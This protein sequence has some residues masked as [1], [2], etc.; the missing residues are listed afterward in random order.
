VAEGSALENY[1]ANKDKQATNPA[2]PA[3][4]Q[5]A[6]GAG[7]NT[8]L[9]AWLTGNGAGT[10][11]GYQENAQSW[12]T[13]A[14]A[15]GTN[16]GWDNEFVSTFVTQ[17]DEALASGQAKDY[18]SRTDATGV[19]T[20]DHTNS[21]G[22]ESYAFG[23]VYEKGKKVGNIYEMYDRDEANL[24]IAPFILDDDTQ[25]RTFSASDRMERL[26]REITAQKEDRSANF[27]KY[28]SALEFEGDVDKRAEFFAE[29]KVDEGI[30]GA[31][32]ILGGA[33][34]YGG[35]AAIAGSA[36]PGVGTVAAGVT[37]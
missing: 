26:D 32:G 23:D 12:L 34:A 16:N 27:D 24:M 30:A 5:Q 37:G 36:A 4:A 9:G 14:N 3:G 20:W 2:A 17:W 28:L 6:A 1:L 33:L 35:A 15:E 10:P 22:T 25:A 13:G 29:G 11:Q 21:A 31:S 19:V 8:E 18:F 7:S